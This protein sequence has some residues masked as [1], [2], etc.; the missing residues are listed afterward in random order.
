MRTILLP[1]AL[2]VALIGDFFSVQGLF[3]SHSAVASA[4]PA[5]M[6]SPAKDGASKDKASA[7]ASGV[8]KPGD[9]VATP[10]PRRI[11]FPDPK[12]ELVL[13]APMANGPREPETWVWK[14]RKSRFTIVVTLA[15]WNS[16]SGETIDYL[17]SLAPL[18]KERSVSLVGAFVNDTIK[19]VERF[20]G[21]HRPRF[22]AGMAG[23]QF[24]ASLESPVTPHYWAIN[25]QGEVM[26]ELVTPSDVERR[27]FF[28]KI[29]RWTEF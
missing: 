11:L 1:I 25:T 15:S 10:Y 2:L 27:A 4:A 23:A 20:M 13:P 12:I 29:L 14:P 5:Q 7:I 16:A 24:V 6:P 9:R 18:L 3:S 8:A 21:E 19:N 22:E 28:N 26:T 17:N